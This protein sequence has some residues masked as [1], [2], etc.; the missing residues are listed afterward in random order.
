[1]KRGPYTFCKKCNRV[2]APDLVDR[3]GRCPDCQGKTAYDEAKNDS[4]RTI[5]KTPEVKES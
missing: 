4:K 2:I 3:S 1:M 5:P